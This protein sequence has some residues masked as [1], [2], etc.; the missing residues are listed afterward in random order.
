MTSDQYSWSS[1]EHC[2]ASKSGLKRKHLKKK[3]S[4][5]AHLLL[6]LNNLQTIKYIFV[7]LAYFFSK[8]NCFK[9]PCD[10]KLHFYLQRLW[11]IQ[12]SL[13]TFYLLKEMQS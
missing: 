13:I 10:L 8:K 5:I 9:K 1:W 6:I 12:R 11:L 3:T 4:K 2:Q 7:I